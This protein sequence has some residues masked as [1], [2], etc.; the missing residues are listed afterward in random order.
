[1][2]RASASRREGGIGSEEGELGAIALVFKL[3]LEPIAATVDVITKPVDES[4]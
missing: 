4:R 3:L 1:M 2:G